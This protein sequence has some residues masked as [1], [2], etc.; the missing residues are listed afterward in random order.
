MIASMARITQQFRELENMAYELDC[1]G[2]PL[3]IRIFSPVGNFTTSTWRVEISGAD[4]VV[5]A[6][7][8]SRALALELVIERWGGSE[9]SGDYKALDWHAIRAA[10][11]KARAF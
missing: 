6:S 8:A 1:S 5:A 9:A 10:L 2:L 11:S 7:A 3:A 4:V